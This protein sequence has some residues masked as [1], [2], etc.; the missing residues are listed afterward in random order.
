MR[1]KVILRRN[2]GRRL[3]RPGARS[4]V[5][6]V[7]EIRIAYH[8]VHDAHHRYA[9]LKTHDGL[10]VRLWDPALVTMVAGRFQ[11]RGFEQRDDGSSYVQEW[12]CDTKIT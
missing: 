12:I 6:L 4:D 11:L 3:D 2:R 1:C 8:S 9:E 10:T 5:D 7:G